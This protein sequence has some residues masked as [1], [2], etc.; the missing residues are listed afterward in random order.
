MPRKKT[1]K[2]A[3]KRKAGRRKTDKRMPGWVSLLMG[4]VIGLGFAGYVYISDLRAPPIPIAILA[5]V[6]P[7]VTRTATAP[8]QSEADKPGF[9]FDF[10]E[11]LPNLDVAVYEDKQP[12]KAAVA[13]TRVTQPG[14]YILQAGSFRKPED[15]NRRKAQIA[16]LGVHT[17][18]KRGKANNREVYRVYTDPMED[19][20]DVN[21]TSERL[22]NANIEI[23]LK[24]VS[25]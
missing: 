3:S 19:P 23:L 6:T 1:R 18:I 12:E 4:L 25:D 2:K 9:G 20:V 21:Q 8:K 11:M 17:E 16:L 15:A 22:R 5:P 24:R 10:Y 7:P 14:I 13:P